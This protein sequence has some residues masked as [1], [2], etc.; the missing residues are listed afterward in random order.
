[1]ALFSFIPR[2]HTKN[3]LSIAR[4]KIVNLTILHLTA[5]VKSK[6]PVQEAQLAALA[7]QFREAS[8]KSKAD[9]ARELGVAAPTI[10]SAE[11]RPEMSLTKLRIRLIE[12]YSPYKIVGPVFFLEKK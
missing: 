7:K 8:G 5:R 4:K 9:A 1:M 11:E 2:V 3:H 6:Q 10:F 12:T